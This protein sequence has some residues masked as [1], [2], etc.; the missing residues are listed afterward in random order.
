MKG[1]LVEKAS[2]YYIII[3]YKDESGKRK[4][5]WISTGLDVKGNKRKAEEFMKEAVKTFEKEFSYRSNPDSDIL[6]AD[7]IEDWLER[8]KP[9]LQISSYGSYQMQVKVI[10]EYFRNKEIKLLDLKPLDISNYYKYLQSK[11]KSIQVCEHHHVNIR[12]ALQTAVKADLIPHNPADRIDRPRSPK[13]IAKFYN[14]K[15]LKKL[16][17]KTKDSRFDYIYKITAL[18]GLRRSEIMGLK[19]KA[20]DFENNII[21]INHA[22][23]QTRINGKSVIIKKDRMKNQSSLRSLPLLPI[24]KRILLE[25]KSK[26]EVNREQFGSLYSK[27]YAE[28]VC[29][30]ELG[31]LLKPDTVSG[32]FKLIIK[33]NTLP[34]IN[35]HELR[36]SCA[37]LLLEFGVGMKEIQEWLGHSTYTTT[38]DIY[39][40]LNYS[41]KLN[42]ASVI[43]NVFGEEVLLEKQNNTKDIANLLEDLVVENTENSTV[44]NMLEENEEVIDDN[45]DL[46]QETFEMRRQR[47]NRKSDI[48]M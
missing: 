40:H 36:H 43:S 35:F 11:G 30:D 16:F 33:K 13:H 15:Q 4:Q 38:A 48:E 41:S 32:H 9:N 34:S 1:I 17:E 46:Y 18:Y 45:E 12:R 7:F 3:T 26:Q 31:V 24:V 2:K 23:V 25:E 44:R 10:S 28:Y 37:S 19:W 27:Q 47:N 29:V 6:F 14:S 22:V 5:K 8:S 42:I 39:S 21:K 20:I